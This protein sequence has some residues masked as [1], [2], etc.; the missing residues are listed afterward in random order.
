[1]DKQMTSP[2]GRLVI[3]EAAVAEELLADVL[4]PLLGLTARGEVVFKPALSG[5]GNRLRVL[6]ALLAAAAASRLGLRSSD[7]VAPK[8]LEGM[9]GIRGNTLRPLLRGLADA[10]LL[11]SESGRYWVPPFAL[12]AVAEEVR[13]G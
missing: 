7:R 10:R 9:A 8:E 1:M 5:K 6:A 3:D 11:Q 4:S 2:L 13:R 12:N